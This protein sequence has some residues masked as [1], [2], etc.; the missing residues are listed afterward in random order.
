[1]IYFTN[2]YDPT[3]TILQL[4]DVKSCPSDVRKNFQPVEWMD[5]RIEHIITVLSKNVA[6][7][8]ESMGEV[9]QN[10]KTLNAYNYINTE[11]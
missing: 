6:Q 3:L 10:V 4:A 9:G 1:M 7:W 5:Q 8:T 2:F 11:L